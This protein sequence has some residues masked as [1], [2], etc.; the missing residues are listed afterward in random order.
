MFNTILFSVSVFLFF[1]TITHGFITI[2]LTKNFNY[3]VE[4]SCDQSKEKCFQRDCINPGDCPPNNLSI[5]KKF[6]ITATYFPECTNGTCDNL[7]KQNPALF[8]KIECDESNGDVCV[9]FGTNNI[10]N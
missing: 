8:H 9:G 5:Y 6:Y 3:L 7:Y 2:Y 10:S 4:V 1:F